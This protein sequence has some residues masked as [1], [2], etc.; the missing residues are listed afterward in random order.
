MDK[1]IIRK[2]ILNNRNK[3]NTNLI[4]EFSKEIQNNLINNDVYKN[5]N[6]IFIYISFGT[7]VETIDIIKNALNL[8]KEVY[9]PKTNKSTKEMDAIRINNFDNM[10]VD[11]WGILEPISVDKNKI[12][13]NFDLIIMPGVAF[14][15]DGNRIGYGGGY[16]D[17]YILNHSKES[18]RLALAYDFQIVKNIKNEE[19]DIKVNYIITEKEFIEIKK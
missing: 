19:H 4:K 11:K 9:V 18:K 16:Y 15:R 8:G 5:S 17:K 3:L 10:T 12:G 1:K 2:E 14:D 13:E 7:E 6:S